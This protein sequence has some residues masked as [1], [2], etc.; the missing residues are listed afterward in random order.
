MIMPETG[1][2][3]AAQP[4]L[5]TGYRH[6]LPVRITHWLNLVILAVMLG[7][8]L[9]IFNAH[10]SLYW[11]DRSDPGQAWLSIE[12]RRTEGGSLRGVTRL[13]GYEVETTGVLGVSAGRDGAEA[14]GFPAWATIPGPRWLAM[15][16]RWHLF[17]AWLLVLNGLVYVTYSLLSRHLTRDL[18]PSL[19]ELKGLG[20]SLR[21]HLSPRRL[22]AQSTR[23]YNPLQKLAY[24]MVV[25]VLGPLV[26]LSGLTM[27]PW[28]DSVFPVL[29]DLFGGR[30][31]ARS[32]HFIAA[33]AF[34]G[35]LLVHLAMVLLVGPVNHVRAMLTGRLKIRRSSQ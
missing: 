35:F 12:A 6:R 22:R 33:F 3:T 25:F 34:V 21:E 27:S 28:L 16:R 9:Q 10:P 24:L 17:F 15:G 32:I 8:G 13:A 20:R 19:P 11:G 5:V 2:E 4:P 23:G 14:R 7:S 1:H 26:L 29:L 18:L 31:S 30:Q